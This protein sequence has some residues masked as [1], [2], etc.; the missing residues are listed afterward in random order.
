LKMFDAMILKRKIGTSCKVDVKI[1]DTCK[2]GLVL[3]V[4]E[5]AV[6][7]NSLTL[8]K[9]FIDK[10]NLNLLLDNEVYFISTQILA[11]SEPIYLSE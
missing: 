6:K 2:D 7:E 3:L 1:Q 9:D 10:N 8:M 11:P 5:K 4:N